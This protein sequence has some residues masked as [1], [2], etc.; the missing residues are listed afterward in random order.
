LA[1]GQLTTL[2]H[3]KNNKT[4]ATCKKIASMKITG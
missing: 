1:V 4:D 3:L 2:I